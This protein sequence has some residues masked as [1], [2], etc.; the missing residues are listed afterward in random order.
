MIRT[1]LTMKAPSGATWLAEGPKLKEIPKVGEPLPFA[2]G[3][4]KITRVFERA[5]KT[6]HLNVELEEEP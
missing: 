4:T 3:K 2:T 1:V 5:D 6:L